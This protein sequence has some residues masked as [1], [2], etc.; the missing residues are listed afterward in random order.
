MLLEA[1]I[2][3]GKQLDHSITAIVCVH[4]LKDTDCNL[5]RY[6]AW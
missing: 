3:F 2:F 5:L 6:L 1:Q 4:P